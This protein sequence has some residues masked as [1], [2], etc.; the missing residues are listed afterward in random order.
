MKKDKQK[1]ILITGAAGFVGKALTKKIS[2]KK[3]NLFLVSRDKKFKIAGANVF[4]GD[5]ADYNFCK[6]I[7]SGIDT[8]FYLAG[9]K[10]N[11]SY[12]TKYPGDFVF[13][14]VEPLISFLK[15]V[16]ESSVKKIIYLSSTNVGLYKEDETDGYVIGKY[17]NE[18]ILKSFSVQSD[19]DIKIIRVPGIYGPGDNFDPDTANFIPAMIRK[20]FGST[21][22]IPV[23]GSGKRKMQFI[24]IDDLVE[25]LLTISESRDKFFV[26]GNPE[27]LT[28]NTITEKIIKLASKNFR[29]KNDATKPDKPTKLFEFYNPVPT[30]MSFENG[31]KKTIDYYKTLNKI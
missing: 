14:N 21:G 25:N 3:R 1:N 17:I 7:I 4:H 6:K 27:N 9:Y 13:G 12:H 19:V 26:V 15:A 30:K 22:E 16:K 5:L 31:M 2:E 29:I 10:K 18:L 24:F 8:V 23:W 20:V 11:I 28:I